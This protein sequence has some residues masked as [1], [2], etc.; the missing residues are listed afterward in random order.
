MPNTR[1]TPAREWL[2]SQ[3]SCADDACLIWPF[4]RDPANG[5]GRIGGGI[6][7]RP[8]VILWTHRVMCQLAHGAPPTKH[9]ASHTCGRGHDGCVNPKHL[10]WK[11]PSDN[12]KD[13]RRHGT[14]KTNHWGKA[15]KFNEFD[16]QQI[17]ILK[18]Y[19]TQQEIGVMFGI[20]FQ[21]VSR[22]QNEKPKV[23]KTFIYR[24]QHDRV[25]I[26]GCRRGLKPRDLAAR[27]GVSM[28]SVEGRIHRLKVAGRIAKERAA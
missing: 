4:F 21:T 1:I 11:T 16:R 17:V 18:D 6:I 3:V 9:E 22:I 24:D 15:G 7:G 20:P 2:L 25:L 27:L 28:G 8:G 23:Y 5:Y 19:L 13:R 14:A 10:E 12:Q 26:E